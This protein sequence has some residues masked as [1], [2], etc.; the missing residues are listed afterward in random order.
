MCGGV[1]VEGGGGGEACTEMTDVAINAMLYVTV[2]WD[3]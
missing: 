2:C 3:G 1:Y